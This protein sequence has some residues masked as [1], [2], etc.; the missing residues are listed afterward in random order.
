MAKQPGRNANLTVNAVAIEVD[1]DSITL[2]VTQETPVVTSLGDTGPRRLAGNYDH[3][4]S[5]S[6]SADFASG[7]SDATLFALIGSAG[8][9]TGFDPTGAT[10][11]A[12]DPNYDTTSSVL[13]SYSITTA[14][15]AAATYQASLPG[16]SALTRAVA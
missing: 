9:A 11:A 13:A 8:V 12:N 7:R 3:N 2:N 5:V 14:M 16:N 10:A 4:K 15:G 1:A 6:G